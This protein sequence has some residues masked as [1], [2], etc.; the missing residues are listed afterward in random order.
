MSIT[1]T[2]VLNQNRSEIPTQTVTNTGVGNLI[3]KCILT[4]NSVNIPPF[5]TLNERH[6]ILA[7]QSIGL[8]DA[9][10]FFLKYFAIGIRGSNCTGVDGLGVSTMKVNQHQPIDMNL[11]VSIPFA[12]RPIDSDFDNV[13]RAK[14]R[15]RVIE[16]IGGVVYAFYYLKLINF[17]N[18]DPRLLKI[19]RDE[20]GNETSVPFIPVK[21]DLFNP[22][23]VDFTSE[24]SVPTSNVYINSSAVLDCTL[25]QTALQELRNACLIKYNDEAYA[26]INEVAL[27]YGADTQTDG[28][29]GQNGII[30]YTEVLSAVIAHFICE[31]D[32][33]SASN[34]TR[35]T[36]AF[37]HGASEPM[38][39]HVDPVT[40]P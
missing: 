28:R 37:D 32:A 34:N 35:V 9:R 1:S 6:N 23:P 31:R 20:D 26:A 36:L 4:G 12:C 25:D 16:E 2:E 19:A 33:R 8:K 7:D 27:V 18:Y 17:E 40:G 39:I 5:T 14:Y 15:L 3:A 11:F 29:V 22:K 10:E 38:L 21:D 13:N 30:R 24:G